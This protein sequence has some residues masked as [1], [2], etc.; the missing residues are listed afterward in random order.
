MDAILGA[1]RGWGLFV[2]DP[3]RDYPR[4]RATFAIDSALNRAPFPA[5]RI[6]AGVP[7]SRRTSYALPNYAGAFL[8]QPASL[9]V[10]IGPSST[11]QGRVLNNVRLFLQRYR[12]TFRF[13]LRFV[14]VGGVDEASFRAA[15]DLLM[16]GL[17]DNFSRPGSG[18]MILT[19][20]LPSPAVL[21][22]VARSSCC[23]HVD[24]NEECTSIGPPGRS[25]TDGCVCVAVKYGRWKDQTLILRAEEVA[26]AKVDALFR[27]VAGMEEAEEVL[28][29]VSEGQQATLAHALASCGECWPHRRI[30][31]IPKDLSDDGVVASSQLCQSLIRIRCL[32]RLIFG[33]VT[34]RDDNGDGSHGDGSLRSDL[35]G[36]MEVQLNICY[37]GSM[38]SDVLSLLPLRSIGIRNCGP[39]EPVTP[40]AQSIVSIESPFLRDVCNL[41]LS[42]LTSLSL[43][44]LVL[45]I[46][47]VANLCGML[48]HESCC[49]QSLEMGGTSYGGTPVLTDD[50]VASFC[51]RMSAF[52]SLKYL[53][54][55]YTVRS[56]DI[57]RCIVSGF[58]SNVTILEV[59]R[60]DFQFD[61]CSTMETARKF[62][63]RT[64]RKD[65]AS[66]L[67]YL[68][69]GH[70]PG[71]TAPLDGL[72]LT[73]C[74]RRCTGETAPDAPLTFYFVRQMLPRLRVA[75]VPDGRRTPHRHEE[76]ALEKGDT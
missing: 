7:S 38:A 50:V 12:F 18:I 49:V 46:R 55:C 13:L 4:D 70:T 68:R 10:E 71:C 9:R 27:S 17:A 11:D 5:L 66:F 42:S 3:D 20:H 29:Y 73:R 2:P 1:L 59:V 48:A 51:R 54:L 43:A 33:G 41:R 36:P 40:R 64:N 53:T 63:T 15:L 28:C 67:E 65:R 8:N 45:T 52:R 58:E 34:F 31:L 37:Y 19:P 61:G 32:E 75:S 72:V 23:H 35:V 22:R 25:L 16:D 76:S 39:L 57:A 74:I 24:Y 62:W 14:P 56:P 6:S 69:R 47:D 44:Y 60:L 26:P 30:T 21:Q